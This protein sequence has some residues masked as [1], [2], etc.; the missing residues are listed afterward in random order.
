MVKKYLRQPDGKYHIKGKIY[1]ILEGSR[2]QVIN[3]TAYRTSG[4]LKKSDIVYN[5]NGH[6]VSLIKSKQA[7]KD[8]RLVKAGYHTKK[9]QF[10]YVYK[11]PTGTKKRTHKKRT[12]K[13]RTGKNKTR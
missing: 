1:D 3:G 11:P 4:G 5:K 2:T 8:N 9:G 6:L 10:G 7:K 13:K 12:H